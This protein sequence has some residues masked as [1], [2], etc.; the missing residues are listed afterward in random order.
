V[1]LAVKD[2]FHIKGYVTTA[3]SKA[4]REKARI[5]AEAVERLLDAGAVVNGKTNLHEFAFGVSNKNPHFGDCINPYSDKHVSGG[6]SGGSAGR[7]GF[8]DV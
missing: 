5:T 1:S 2:V 6:S 8:G 7:C 4:Y 3:G